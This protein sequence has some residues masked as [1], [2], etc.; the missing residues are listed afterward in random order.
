MKNVFILGVAICVSLAATPASAL[1]G[2]VGSYHSSGPGIP[3]T[4]G[5]FGERVTAPGT[6]SLGTAL[7]SSSI[8]RHPQKG[9]LL[10]PVLP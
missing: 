7:S 6:N 3:D 1:V 8:G 10:G 5:A 9:A 2:G 4:G